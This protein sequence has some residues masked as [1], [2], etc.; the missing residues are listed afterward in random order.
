MP[1]PEENSR[2][3]ILLEILAGRRVDDAK[4]SQ[5][6]A[7]KVVSQPQ[8]FASPLLKTHKQWGHVPMTDKKGFE[9]ILEPGQIGRV[10]TKNRIIKACG[11]AEDVAGINRAFLE[12]IARGGAGLIVWGDVAVEYPRG[13]TLPITHRHLEDDRNIPVFREIAEVV[14]KHSCP[15][16]MQLFHAGPQA[17]L[18]GGLQ[19]ISSSS[20]TESEISELTASMGPQELTIPEIEDLVDKFAGAAVRAQK[21]GFDGVEVNAA[22]MHLINSFLSRAWN[23]RKDIYGCASLQNRAR[24]LVQ[25]IREIKKRSGQ[26]FPV[27]TLINGIELRI[28]KG[29]TIEEAQEFAV[30][31]QD[32]GVD[33]IH[34]RAFGYHGFQI[35]DAS[36]RGIYHSENTIPL[37]K[38]LDW[39][40]KGRGAMA[41]LAAA[42]KK[43]VCIPVIAVGGLDAVV[44]ERIL[45]EGK[46]DF[47]AMCKGLMADP[48]IPNKVAA[49][50]LDDIAPCADC[51]DCARELFLNITRG[52]FVPIRCRVNAALGFDQ[53]YEIPAAQKKKKVVV[54][55]GGPAG[56]E[57]ARVAAI[58]GHEVMLYE[59]E[60]RLGGLLR[61]V[62]LIR[63]LDVDSDVMILADYLKK[64]ITRLGVSIRLGR[65]LNPSMI[66]EIDPDAVILATGGMPAV[67]E[68]HG[69]DRSNVV[70]IDDLY[71][72][73]KDDLELIEP[74]IMR[75][76]AKYWEFIGKTVAV[77]GG[78]IEGS[79]LAQF[80]VERCRNVTI[81][82]QGTIWGD[83]PLLR[84]PSMEKVTR[85]P[86]V[87]YE[88]I[89]DKGLIVT[90]RDGKRQ[91]I[92]ADT[93][94]TATSPRLNTDLLKAL[95]GKVP[96][97]YLVGNEDKEPSSIMTAIGNGYRLARAI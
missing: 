62:A 95:E 26:D 54:V 6:A 50:R 15:I 7:T 47:I 46:A 83:E 17:L 71:R 92:E 68:I 45:E 49:G 42:V 30:I 36:P 65:E 22:R 41:P 64:Q 90:T 11:G 72:K 63:G 60:N 3:G 1:V 77:I 14:H 70:S 44:G 91:T 86:G 18:G 20:L 34:V 51:G 9:K 80:L 27:T 35:V 21:A 48:E 29:I 93:V 67:P 82:E 53:D 66:R 56:M 74:G 69:I 24:F 38:E 39:S 96:E 28:D 79:G 23:K 16:F 84:S 13:V 40:R 43:V 87:K 37:P 10:R 94:I 25:I 89:T 76:M 97:V 57:A 59:R 55:G 85:M 88:E 31:L 58:R 73:M 4:I 75:W 8:R 33:A 5:S 78:T 2:A 19:T 12:A 32:A 52:E 61:W 81:A